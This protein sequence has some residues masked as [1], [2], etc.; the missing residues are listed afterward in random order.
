MLDAA[1]GGQREIVGFDS[2]AGFPKPEPQDTSF[3]NPKEGEWSH[4]PSGKYEYSMEF[5]YRVL[6]K[7]RLGEAVKRVNLEKGFFSDTLPH[8]S[9]GPIAILHL[10]GDLYVSYRDPLNNLYDKVVPGGVIVF[11]DFTTEK[12]GEDRFP[13]ARMATE[14][15]FADKPEQLRDSIRGTPYLVKQ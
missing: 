3:R 11:D 12:A 10:D 7:A 5:I 8:Y 2:F 14:E 6:D 13:G 9:G 1:E 4:S 15:F